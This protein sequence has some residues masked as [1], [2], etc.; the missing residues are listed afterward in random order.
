MR[1]EDLKMVTLTNDGYIDYTQNLINSLKKLNIE[2]EIT[3]YSVGKKSH[4]HFKDQS[5]NSI[6]LKTGLFD[7]KNYFQNWRSKNFNKLMFI[8]LSII[9]ENLLNYNQVLYSDGDVVFLKN[10]LSDIKENKKVDIVGQ[11]DFNPNEEVETLCAGFMMINSNENTLKLF[12]P[13]NVPNN[14]LD[15]HY[16]FDDQKYIN[17]HLSNVSYEFLDIN[18]YPN[19]AYFYKNY[20]KLKPSIVHFNYIVGDEKMKKMKDMGYW[21][22]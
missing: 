8:K 1:K 4:K 9:Y 22:K 19:G 17:Q 5:L 10:F 15:R 14:L 3:I 12:D 7:K 21:F 20:L 6:Y 2:K 11:L 18:E 16:Y 13:K